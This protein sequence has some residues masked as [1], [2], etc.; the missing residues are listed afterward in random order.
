VHSLAERVT[1]SSIAVVQPSWSEA[2]EL[3][4]K[5]QI[6]DDDFRHALSSH[7]DVLM[8]FTWFDHLRDVPGFSEESWQ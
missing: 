7:S 1:V 3:W 5:A 4:T 6:I 2:K 8:Q